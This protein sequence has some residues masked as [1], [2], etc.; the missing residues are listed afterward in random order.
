M[1]YFAARRTPIQKEEPM[2]TANVL[3]MQEPPQEFAMDASD[4]LEY[5]ANAARAE[6][7]GV[8]DTA[9]AVLAFRAEQVDLI[10]RVAE[11]RW[12]LWNLKST[13]SN[14]RPQVRGLVRRLYA[15]TLNRSFA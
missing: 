10:R 15:L 14:H 5:W 8:R 4:E 13:H 6:C 12:E 11:D 3:E 9:G 7:T 2:A 1:W